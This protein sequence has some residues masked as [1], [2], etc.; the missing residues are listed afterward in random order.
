MP[1]SAASLKRHHTKSASFVTLIFAL[2]ASLG[3]VAVAQVPRSQSLSLLTRALRLPPVL[4][5]LRRDDRNPSV[6]RR[7]LRPKTSP[8][9][10]S[11]PRLTSG[12]SDRSHEPG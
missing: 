2:A 7:G 11:R 4:T 1:N 8:H 12:S 3:T 5:P 10:P 6:R 9:P